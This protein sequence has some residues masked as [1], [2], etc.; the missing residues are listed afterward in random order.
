[1]DIEVHDLLVYQGVYRITGVYLGGPNQD[2]CVTVEPIVTGKEPA[3]AGAY[4][5]LEYTI[6]Y[7][8][9]NSSW[10]YRPVAREGK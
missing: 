7:A 3:S 9:I 1:M 10:V 6:P 4:L 5:V 8:M 2:S